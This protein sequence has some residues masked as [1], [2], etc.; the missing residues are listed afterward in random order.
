LKAKAEKIVG[1]P[2]AIEYGEK[3]VGVV[4]YRDSSVIDLI[5]EVSR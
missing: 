4:S 2:K 3:I 1:H 5:R